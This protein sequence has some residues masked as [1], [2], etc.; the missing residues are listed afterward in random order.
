MFAAIQCQFCSTQE[1][2][3]DLSKKCV[4]IIQSLNIASIIEASANSLPSCHVKAENQI[5]HTI[6][7]NN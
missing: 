7:S 6:E 2:I 4:Y 5:M 1:I 3:V